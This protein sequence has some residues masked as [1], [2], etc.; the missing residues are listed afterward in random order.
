MTPNKYQVNIFSSI[1]NKM[2]LSFLLF[3]FSSIENQPLDPVCAKQALY[4]GNTLTVLTKFQVVQLFV[5]LFIWL[6]V[7]SLKDWVIWSLVTL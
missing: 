1:Q 2:I 5:C 3:F 4:H 6:K 7:V